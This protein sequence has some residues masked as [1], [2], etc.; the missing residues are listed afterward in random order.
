MRKERRTKE[1]TVLSSHE[2]DW[3]E[4]QT[5]ESDCSCTW[6]YF[7]CRATVEILLFVTS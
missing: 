4:S 2:F 7:I 3:G 5:Q 1:Q 6:V